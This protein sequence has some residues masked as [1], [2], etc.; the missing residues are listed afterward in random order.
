MKVHPCANITDLVVKKCE[1]MMKE[2]TRE[3]GLIRDQT[4]GE[5][6]GSATQMPSVQ[7]ALATLADEKEQGRGSDHQHTA[8]GAA[9]DQKKKTQDMM[10][11]CCV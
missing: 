8:A 11:K 6:A 5:L 9:E 1:E 4:T 3:V 7:E 10:D 2:M